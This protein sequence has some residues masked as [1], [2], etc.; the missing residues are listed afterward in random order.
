MHF[1]WCSQAVQ[2]LRVPRFETRS[3]G[4]LSLFSVEGLLAGV[5][6]RYFLLR[7]YLGLSPLYLSQGS[8]RAVE[9]QPNWASG[10]TME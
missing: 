8:Q 2:R 4:A 5:V 6:Y 10:H 3:V 1:Q 9:F 7:L